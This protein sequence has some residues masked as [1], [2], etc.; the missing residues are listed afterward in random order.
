MADL[1]RGLLAPRRAW[2]RQ[3]LVVVAVSAA[4][5]A[6]LAIVGSLLAPAVPPTRAVTV[7][8][9]VVVAR[10]PAVAPPLAATRP[11][12][13]VDS[14]RSTPRPTLA[15]LVAPLRACPPP[16]RDAP[17]LQ[18]PRLDEPID[19][20]APSPSNAGW[21]AA[22][23]DEHVFASLD[24][25]RTFARVLDGP[26]RVTGVGFDCFG[27]VVV[28]RERQVGLRVGADERWTTIDGV[29][30]VT[31]PPDPDPA[32]VRGQAAVVSGGPELVVVGLIEPWRPRL[33]RSAD[34][35]R[36]WRYHDLDA[37]WESPVVRGRQR[38]D[39]TIAITLPSS[40][41]E[42]EAEAVVTIRDGRVT[43]AFGGLW[44]EPG[45]PLER[46]ELP[47]GLADG[48]TWAGEGLVVAGGALHR[49]RGRGAIRLPH[50]V[51]ADEYVADAAGRLWAVVCNQPVIAGRARSGA[52]C[53]DARA[54]E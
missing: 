52:A 16:R 34:L 2:R 10:P 44:Y 9:A 41:C 46:D 5:G 39:G 32:L 27:T 51:E 30:L 12:V 29:S 43:S 3:A 6:H 19:H 23:N 24:A 42:A 22:W 13:T 7:P 50:V 31:M 4:A 1:A 49:L 17:R 26:G 54:S 36:T 53:A 8:V 45:A 37:D 40:D 35:G 21:I 20:L 14:E 25:G 18:P 15:P 33:A 47:A 28:V 38:E 48:A 11:E